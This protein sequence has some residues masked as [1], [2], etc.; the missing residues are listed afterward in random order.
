MRNGFRLWVEQFIRSIQKNKSTKKEANS[1]KLIQS[2]HG[3]TGIYDGEC[4]SITI[5]SAENCKIEYGMDL[6]NW[7]PTVPSICDAG[8]H[9]VYVKVSSDKKVEFGSAIINIQKRK[10]TLTSSSEVKQLLH[11]ASTQDL[12]HT[13][14]LLGFY[15]Y[16]NKPV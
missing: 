11:R 12:G 4:H 3:Y 8:V 1:P 5:V 14:S 13:L 15:T 7:G 16:H 6:T 10:I 2:L 9:K